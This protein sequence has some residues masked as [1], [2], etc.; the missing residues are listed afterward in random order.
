[1]IVYKERYIKVKNVKSKIK[2]KMS[3]ENVVFLKGNSKKVEFSNGGSLINSTLNVKQLVE[4]L[5]WYNEER[6]KRGL[7]PTEYLSTTIK[8]RKDVDDYGNTHY[9]IFEPWFPEAKGAKKEEKKDGLP[10]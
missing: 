2:K 9:V 5:K 3:K 1:M 8:E 6:A 10:F 4:I 7:D